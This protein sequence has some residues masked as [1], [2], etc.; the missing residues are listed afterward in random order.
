MR[1][2]TCS[3]L[4]KVR[5]PLYDIMFEKNEAYKKRV[6]V[7]VVMRLRDKLMNPEIGFEVRLPTVDESIRTQVNSVL[8]TEQEL[9]RQVF[10]LIVLNR[11]VSTAQPMPGWHARRRR[12]FRRDHDERTIEQP[13]EQLVVEVERR[14]R[15]RCELPAGGQHHPGRVGSGHEYPVV[16]RAIVVE[17]QPGCD[18]RRS[19]TASNTN[20]TLIGDFQLEYLLTPEGRLRVKAFSMS[21]D[22]NLTRTDQIPTTQG[23]GV[24]YREEFRTLRRTVAEAAEQLP[25]RKERTGTSIEQWIAPYRLP[26]GII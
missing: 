13:G 22:R 18:V 5:A 17:H 1:S 16:Q 12:E 19:Q 26:I 24:V 10:A 11:F 21:N 6:P 9:N 2:W 3:A 8:S 20:N 14:F 4:Y 15:P 23:A 7:D 25:A